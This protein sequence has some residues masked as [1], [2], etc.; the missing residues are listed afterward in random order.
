MSRFIA[1]LCSLVPLACVVVP[2]PPNL[3][4]ESDVPSTGAQEAPAA[5]DDQTNGFV[6]QATFDGDQAVFNDVEVISDG[7]GPLFNAASCLACHQNPVS[8]G[9]SQVSELRAGKRDAYGHFEPARVPIARGTVII[10]GRTLINDRAICPNGAFPDQEI[11]EHVPDSANIR[12]FRLSVSVLGDGFVEAVAD[13]SLRTYAAR[14]C[15]ET[16]GQI[17]GHAFEVPVLEAPGMNR[18]GRFGW[19]GQQAS[20]LSFSADAYLNEMGITSRLLPDEVT[21]LCDTV[22]D[23]EDKP[24]SPA[25]ARRAQARSRAAVARAPA[26]PTPA[27][28]AD[29]DR[30]A[31]F[32]RATKA[33][34]RDVVLAQTDAARKGSGL[35][36]SIG[37][38][39][40]HARNL[41]TAPA[42]TKING[43]TFTVPPALGNR[44]FHPFSDFLMHDV[45]TGDGIEIATAEHFGKRFAHMQQQMSPTADR[46]RTAPLW[47][48]RTRSRLMHDGA[49]L[50]LRDAID[51]HAGEAKSARNRYTSLSAEEQETLLTFLRSL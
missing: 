32:M 16:Q 13:E 36:D 18:V 26:P 44:L 43:G 8:G 33:P 15:K 7:L 10:E 45:G 12:T 5:F 22:P 34:P 38:A 28:F 4:T 48:V 27:E 50:T 21:K 41:V 17:C 51:R 31:R 1:L 23:P 3:G 37:C 29:I 2:V 47:G 6:E 19:K 39:T 20:L 24:E 30:F 9:G 11:Q 46:I 40:C 42:G 49:S 14:Q 35:F 25:V